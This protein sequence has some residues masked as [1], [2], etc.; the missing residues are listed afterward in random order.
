MTAQYLT[1]RELAAFLTERGYPIALQTLHRLC[2]PVCGEGPPH[3]GFWGGRA[4][5]EPEK[6]LAWAKKRFRSH[7]R[8]AAIAPD[9]AG[10]VAT[11]IA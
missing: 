10:S 7:R 11:S 6:A 1:R 5:Y 8:A 3:A 4:L 9:G 2:M